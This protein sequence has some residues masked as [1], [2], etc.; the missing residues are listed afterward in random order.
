[1][2]ITILRDSVPSFQLFKHLTNF[3]EMLYGYWMDIIPLDATQTSNQG[4]PDYDTRLLAT[5]I[6][7]SIALMIILISHSMSFNNQAS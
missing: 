1:M 7:H 3:H 6:S 2:K 4:A 5:T